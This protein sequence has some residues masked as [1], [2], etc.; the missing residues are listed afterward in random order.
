MVRIY[1]YEEKLDEKVEAYEQKNDARPK[2]PSSI[3]ISSPEP[4]PNDNIT[5]QD[6]DLEAQGTASGQPKVHSIFT[7]RQKTFIVFMMCW[8]GIISPITAQ[9]YFPALNTLSA[10]LHVS[11][12]LINLTLTSYMIFQGLAPS[13][14]GDLSDMAGRRPT[15]VI[16]FIIYIAA[17]IGLALQNSYAALFILRCVQ[18]SGSSGMVAITS[19]VVADIATSAERGVWMGWSMSALM[20][21]PAIGPVLGGILAQFLGWRSIFWF[22]TIFAGSYLVPFFILYPETCRN[23][24]GDGSIRPQGWNMSLIAYLQHRKLQKQREA[25]AAN[26]TLSRTVSRDSQRAAR[27]ALARKR[28]LRFPNPWN[29][30]KIVFEKDLGLLLLYNSIIYT[31]FFDILASQPY[32]FAQI[33]GFDDLQIGIS[34][35]PFGV[36]AM[37]APILIGRLLDWNFARTARQMGISVD[38]RVA[39]NLKDFPLEKVR[40]AVAT[41]LIYIGLVCYVLYGWMLEINA[42][43][44]AP[45][46]LHFVIGLTLTGGFNA[47]SVLLVDVYLQAPATATAANNLVRCLI[48]AAGTGII[49]EMVD[50]MGRGWCFTFIALV[51]AAFSPIQ[52]VLIKWGPQWREERRQRIEREAKEKALSE[53]DVE[54]GVV[55]EENHP[56]EGQA[57]VGEKTS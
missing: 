12:T 34:C 47:Q 30:I 28:E 22:L 24:V 53:G 42:P 9:I 33:Y 43:L 17:N 51:V 20:I 13:I 36:G 57:P 27:A 50:A 29:T 21:G 49:V 35:I 37:C 56:V 14:M 48:G 23:I 31:S 18:S 54:E 41:P 2:T 32:L 44:A 6:A 1:A 45:L 10:D 3:A 11:N 16:G 5:A 25:D 52:W 4:E 38:R 19:G 15:I 7:K 55:G 40:L 8:G 46:I 39:Q 26:G